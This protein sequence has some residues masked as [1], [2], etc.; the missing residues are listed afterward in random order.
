M[1][2]R[3]GLNSD[4]DD[5]ISPSFSLSSYLK[6]MKKEKKMMMIKSKVTLETKAELP[7][8]SCKNGADSHLL[9]RFLQH[10]IHVIKN[11]CWN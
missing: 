9:Y 3:V 4:D 5:K 10:E 2:C 6:K 8:Y 7:F 11:G 1:E